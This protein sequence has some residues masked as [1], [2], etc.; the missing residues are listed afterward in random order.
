MIWQNLYTRSNDFFKK[1]GQKCYHLADK[2]KE[3]G[4]KYVEWFEI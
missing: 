1:L 3:D 4:L 2:T